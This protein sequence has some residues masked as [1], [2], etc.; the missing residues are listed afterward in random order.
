MDV[1]CTSGA[2]LDR[3]NESFVGFAGFAAGIDTA[4]VLGQLAIKGVNAGSWSHQK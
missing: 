2:V 3:V 1:K 4:P